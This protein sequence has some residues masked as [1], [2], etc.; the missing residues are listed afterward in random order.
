L[1]EQLSRTAIER[2]G[3]RFDEMVK[4]VASRQADPY[5]VVEEI[6]EAR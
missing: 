5:S 1:R 6:V 3:S 4:Q 2:L